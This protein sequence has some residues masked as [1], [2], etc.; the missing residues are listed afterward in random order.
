MALVE[1]SEIEQLLLQFLTP[2]EGRFAITNGSLETFVRRAA[3]ELGRGVPVS[4]IIS[5]AGG[6]R[7]AAIASA[8]AAGS[9]VVFNGLTI[10]LLRE[11]DASAATASCLNFPAF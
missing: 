10:P 9:E 6:A 8:T 5:A 1:S 4:A 3:Y 7:E 11:T 2:G